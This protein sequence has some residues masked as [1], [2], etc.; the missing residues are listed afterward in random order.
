MTAKK[1]NYKTI[2]IKCERKHSRRRYTTLVTTTLDDA[3]ADRM[4]CVLRQL[5]IS[6]SEL[7]R[8]AMLEYLGTAE[9]AQACEFVDAP[10]S[11]LKILAL[12]LRGNNDRLSALVDGHA[13]DLICEEGNDEPG[14]SVGEERSE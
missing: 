14:E 2:G 9:Q 4:R 12:Q 13:H 10:D 1:R 6:C 11:S 5:R 7:M 3:T 8:N